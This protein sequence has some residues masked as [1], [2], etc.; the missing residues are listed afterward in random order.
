M[1]L[2][3]IKAIPKF[4]VHNNVIRPLIILY[5]LLYLLILLIL[6]MHLLYLL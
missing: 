4:T 5:L 6:T 2:E 1:N 3:I